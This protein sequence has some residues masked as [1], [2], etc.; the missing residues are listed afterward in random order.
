M[1]LLEFKTPLSRIPD[2]KIPK[3]YLPQI[4]AGMCALPMVEGS[5]FVNT[6]LRICD[7]KDLRY[8]FNYNTRIHKSD[9]TICKTRPVTHKSKLDQIVAFGLCLV[10]QTE[11]QRKAAEDNYF[12]NSLN[13]LDPLLADLGLSD[14]KFCQSYDRNFVVYDSGPTLEEELFKAPRPSA[15]KMI[16]YVYQASNN[17]RTLY[18][19]WRARY[20][21]LGGGGGVI[22]P[23]Q[24]DTPV[25][26]NADENTLFR[27]SL[28]YDYEKC[29]GNETENTVDNIF[30][31]VD[32]N[33][34]VS[35]YHIPPYIV[36]D[37]LAKSAFFRQCGL[38][39]SGNQLDPGFISADMQMYM[40]ESINYLR[41]ELEKQSVY[42]VGMIPYKVFKVDFIFQPNDDPKFMKTLIS[43]YID[44][45]AKI[46]AE[47]VAIDADEKTNDEEKNKSKWDV[48]FK[49]FPDKK[50][51]D[52]QEREETSKG[53][54]SQLDADD[55][56]F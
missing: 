32:Q 5:L 51:A 14:G 53:L 2:G 36:T 4:K 15:L 56:V 29:Y 10:I 25:S 48:V 8:D 35:S 22:E 19:G 42:I 11:Q 34:Y 45:Y 49:Y 39:H 40:I 54:M 27:N 43:P 30:N 47:C 1:A 24:F 7:L 21:Q 13:E 20:P 18:N 26:C 33:K 12:D 46:K 52:N 23:I 50:P 6:M 9:T 16:D 28:L 37:N 44:I 17:K 41:I 55:F 3:E 38:V 31:Y